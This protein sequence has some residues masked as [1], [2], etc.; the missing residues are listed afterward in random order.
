MNYEQH[1]AERADW[2]FL[3][4]HSHVLICLARN[5]DARLRDVA[6]DV[7]ITERAVQRIV[8]ELERAGVIERQREG[9]R[10]R[11]RIAREVPLRH[12]VEAHCTVGSLLQLI[13]SGTAARESESSS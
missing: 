6:S 8:L 2:T 12:P 13:L 11:Y 3:T 10:N 5:P 9:R 7:G 4:N 1:T